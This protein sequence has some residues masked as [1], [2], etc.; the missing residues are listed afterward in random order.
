M[1]P[2]NLYAQL[3]ALFGAVM[4]VFYIG[5]GFFFILSN[6]LSQIDS[7]VR[8]LVGGTFIFYGTFRLYRTIISIKEAFFT[9]D[10]DNE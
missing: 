2:K 3:M 4:T 1:N 5:I 10:N 9:N 7:F 8:Y 6:N